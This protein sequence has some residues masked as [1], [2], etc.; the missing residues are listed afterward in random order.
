MPLQVLASVTTIGPSAHPTTATARLCVSPT[1]TPK[2][3]EVLMDVLV[4][5]ELPDPA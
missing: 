2:A 3:G 4:Q 1:P 5:E